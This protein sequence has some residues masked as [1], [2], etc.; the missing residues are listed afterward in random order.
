MSK[1]LT[2]RELLEAIHRGV[3]GDKINGTKGLIEQ[4]KD[5]DKINADHEKRIVLIE[6]D[7]KLA[8]KAVAVVTTGS[9]LTGILVGF[10]ESIF[11]IFE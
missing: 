6:R 10:K 8:I 2:N 1:D 3:Y 4:Q 11:K 5:D 9:G 7:R